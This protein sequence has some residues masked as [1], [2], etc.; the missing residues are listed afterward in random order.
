MTNAELKAYVQRA[1]ELE[2]AIYTQKKLMSGHQSLID[3]Q[4]PVK[5][6]K[7]EIKAPERPRVP[8]EQKGTILFWSTERL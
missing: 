3:K 6:Q 7:Q 5:P 2:A 8:N 4:C 1:K